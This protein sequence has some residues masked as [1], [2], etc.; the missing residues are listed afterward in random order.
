M[1]KVSLF[2]QNTLV[3]CSPDSVPVQ[4]CVGGKTTQREAPTEASY[5]LQIRSIFTENEDGGFCPPSLPSE[6]IYEGNGHYKQ[7]A[8]PISGP[9][10]VKC[11]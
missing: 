9:V 6:V 2:I 5:Q 4:S 11:K 1:S 7:Q 10:D 3:S 8:K